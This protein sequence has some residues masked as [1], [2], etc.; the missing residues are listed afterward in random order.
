MTLKLTKIGFAL[1]SAVLGLL[2]V[3]VSVVK[4]DKM[5]KKDQMTKMEKMDKMAHNHNHR[6]FD[7]LKFE[8]GPKGIS[9]A[10]L[11]GDWNNGGDYGMIVKIKAGH[12]APDHRHTHDYH[13]V[14][15]QGKWAHRGK[16]GKEVVLSQG[17]YS[18]QTGTENHG[19][20]CVG[21]EDCL[22]LI[23]Q[24]GKRDFILAKEK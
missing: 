13:G 24:H 16:D 4:A 22:I 18:K 17:S 7:D 6:S 20:R 9:F 2:L 11:W 5:V 15:I 10:L 1:A 3:N 19:D 12:A 23:H 8:Q 21:P 14:T